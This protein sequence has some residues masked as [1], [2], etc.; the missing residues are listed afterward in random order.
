MPA[1]D[2][3]A[4]LRRRIRT[5]QARGVPS[6]VGVLVVDG[7]T[8]WSDAVGIAEPGDAATV[9]HHYRIGS[10]TKTFAAAAT[11]QLRDAGLLDLDDDIRRHLREIPFAKVT[12]RRLLTH[13]S[14]LQREPPGNIWETLEA[15]TADRLLSEIGS[16]ELV[17]P[18]GRRWHYSNLGY[19]LLGLIVSRVAAVPF[20]DYVAEH[21]LRPLG[22]ART[23]WERL[24]PFAR[25]YFVDP[26][27]DRLRPEP[28]VDLSGT[29][30]MGGLWSTADDLA[31]WVACLT[32]AEPRVLS[33]RTR[34]EMASAHV[35]ADQESWAV[36]WGLGLKLH[37]RGDTVVAGHGGSMPGY[38]AA[39]A[40]RHQERIGAVV[41][42]NTS[43]ACDVEALAVELVCDALAC[44]REDPV[45]WHPGTA[46]P[47]SLA[48]ALGRWWS[49]GEPFEFSMREGRLRA[50][51]VS[52]PDEPLSE[53][54]QD[55]ADTFQ[56]MTGREAGERLQLVRDADGNV[57]KLYWATYPFTRAPG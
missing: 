11:L 35:V 41:L 46:A 50:Q 27:D 4:C 24:P 23:G 12:I 20:D 31:R 56:T 44:D 26:F 18:P 33:S 5:T 25:G 17:H 57:V 52:G 14:G 21:I 13:T 54:A 42:T 28:D 19:A 32:R 10:I 49:E 40:L 34:D 3:A 7:R 48:S 53:F 38:L 51:R 2:L 8:A 43:A 16:A 37:R 6:V 22:I 1:P 29:A 45:P 39:I 36:G 30:S 9:A 15:P 55:D 47:A